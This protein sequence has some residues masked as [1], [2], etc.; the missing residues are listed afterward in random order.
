M[1]AGDRRRNYIAPA[2]NEAGYRSAPNRR[3][4]APEQEEPDEGG[5]RKADK[6]KKGGRVFTFDKKKRKI[7]PLRTPLTTNTL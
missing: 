4:Q 6:T 3:P 2:R 5:E 1:S 7:K